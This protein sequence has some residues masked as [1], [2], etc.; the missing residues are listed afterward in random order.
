MSKR[1]EFNRE[2]VCGEREGEE[3]GGGTEDRGSEEGGER[4]N[5]C[6]PGGLGSP[7]VPAD[8]QAP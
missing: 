2:L 4:R 6:A 7:V 5:R 8:P 1:D 3:R